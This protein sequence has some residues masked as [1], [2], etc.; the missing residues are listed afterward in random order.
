MNDRAPIRDR[1]LVLRILVPG[2][3]ARLRDKMK[4]MEERAAQSSTSSTPKGSSSGAG[5]DTSNNSSNNAVYLDL[6]GVTCE[7]TAARNRT[8]WHFRCDGATYP[9]RLVNL[10]CPV[11]LHKTHD[12]A[13][14]YKC[15]DLAQMLIVYEDEMA[16][17]EADEKPIEGFPSYYPSG[18]TPPTRRI[19]ERRFDAREHKAVAPPRAAV[20]DVEVELLELMEKLSKDEKN[21]R[22]NKVP[23]LTSATK[24]LEEVV[25]EAVEYEPWMD[26][27]G[28]QPHGIE[29]DA[30]DQQINSHPE[31]WI[32][33]DVIEQVKGHVKEQEEEAKKKKAEKAAAQE[34]KVAKR[35]TKKQSKEEQKEASA[36][37]H[38]K[39]GIAS[40]KNREPVD[41]VTQIAE[42]MLTADGGLDLMGEA[43]EDD[44]F[45]GD[46]NLADEELNFE[47]MNL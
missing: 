42:S 44:D 9:A 27:Y 40:K 26:D 25:E 39:K 33:P 38:I 47:E 11:E 1:T 6:E 35:K 16:L 32:S 24:V 12:H 5:A 37:P 8:L 45:F 7:P 30:D 36:V 43:L 17:E 15:C 46:F 3:E 22:K 41:E 20:A 31:V 21:R 10:P 2:L 23:T 28:R 18:L 13:M 19:V 14:Y 34:K 4:E 29:L